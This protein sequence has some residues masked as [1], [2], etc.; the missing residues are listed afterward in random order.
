M[1]FSLF[2]PISKVDEQQRLVFGIAADE[3]P[4]SADEIFDYDKSKPHF[5]EWSEHI[6][7]ATGGKSVG[8][9]RAQHDPQKPAGKLT[10]IQF[11]D[12]AK[13]IEIAAKV[14]DEDAWMKVQEGVFTGFSIGGKYA[15]R[16][17]DGDLTR[18]S[19][20]PFEISLVDLPA[21]PSATFQVIKSDGTS[22]E[23]NF[24]EKEQK[25]KRVDGVDL[26]P[27][28]FAYVGDPS[29][30]DTW[31]LPIEFPGDEE[32]TKSHI[33]NALARFNQTEG[34]P[35]DE[36]AKVKAKILAAAERHGIDA[37]ENHEKAAVERLD[38]IEKSIA[39]LAELL[40]KGSNAPSDEEHMSKVHEHLQHIK[41]L[42]DEHHEAVSDAID[43]A[44]AACDEDE[45]A[46]GAPP[47]HPASAKGITAEDLEKAM[48]EAFEAGIK[49]VSDAIKGQ[50]TVATGIG[51]RSKV[52][53]VEAVPQEET[54]AA[55]ARAYAAGDQAAGVK[56]MKR[57]KPTNQVPVEALKVFAGRR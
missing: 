21:N 47:E 10:D 44:M 32:K 51:D 31:K 13:S 14:V 55:L 37:A 4:D 12:S 2:L 56:L 30:P 22:E 42:H 9:L 16:W 53:A 23:R 38:R 8:N 43:K 45:E 19:A 46:E 3:T 27:S 48:K 39:A 36:R 11:N 49:A 57:V 41:R 28:S 20:I 18:Y 34:I 33:R 24:M 50:K 7:E 6:K 25:T 52:V 35:E 5:E 26:P 54:D 15:D 40:E 17:R 29:R 1:A